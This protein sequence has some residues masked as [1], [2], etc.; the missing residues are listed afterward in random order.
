MRNTMRKIAAALAAGALIFSA[1]AFAKD[2]HIKV[3][4]ITGPEFQIAETVKQIAKEKYSLEVELVPFTEY[5][6]VN[7]ALESKELDANAIQHYPYLAEQSKDRGWTDL[8]VVGN[9]FVYPMAA[10]SHKIKS[11]EEV[12]DGMTVA[13]PSDKTNEGRALLLLQAKGLITL[14]NPKDLNSSILDIVENPKNLNIKT[15]D[16]NLIPR[17]LSQ[18]DFAVINNTFAGQGGLTIEKDGIFVENADSPYVNIIV[19]RKDNAEDPDVKNFVKAY[20][21]EKTYE[22]AKKLFGE[23]VKGWK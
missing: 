1:G 18:L 4:V 17:A 19:A 11:L 3:G 13:I 23:V 7:V 20:N 12:K 15:I 6:P 10:Y 9:T 2:G 8:V 22:A 5:V 14:K 16:G 21:D